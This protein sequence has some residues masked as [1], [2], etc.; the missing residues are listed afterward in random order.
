MVI[1]KNWLD[2]IRP[3]KLNVQSAGG[4]YGV[5]VLQPATALPA[6]LGILER[7]QE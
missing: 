1:D 4:S 2:L 6:A 7:E 5:A 3:E